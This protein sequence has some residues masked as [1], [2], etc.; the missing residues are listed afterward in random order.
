[1]TLSGNLSAAT[2]SFYIPHPTRPG[3][4]LQYASLEGPENGV[5]I[6]GKIIDTD[7]IVLPDYWSGLIDS[8][9]ITVNL[10]GILSTDTYYVKEIGN[11]FV[12]IG[13]TGTGVI[14]CYFII[15]AERKD[16][17]KLLVEH[18]HGNLL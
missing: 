7:T 4:Y 13:K 12:K 2:K 8:E 9:T 1:L 5:Y 10:T 18:G 15:F 14:N 6:R 17:P 3:M 11:G 16:V